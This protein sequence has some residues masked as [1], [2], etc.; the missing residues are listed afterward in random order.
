MADGV[1]GTRLHKRGFGS[2]E[3]GEV[4]PRS[5][6]EALT[7]LGG[8]TPCLWVLIGWADSNQSIQVE[9]TGINVEPK[10]EQ[11]SDLVLKFCKETN[12]QSQRTRPN[13]ETPQK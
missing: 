1:E 3:D 4:P 7:R 12:A 6:R 8:F 10:L 5:R 2:A 13:H 11:L 9:I